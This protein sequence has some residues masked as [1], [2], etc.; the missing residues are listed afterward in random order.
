MWLVLATVLMAQESTEKKQ[1]KEKEVVVVATRSE[2]DVLDVAAGVT[3][4]TR[5]QIEKSGAS[6][7][8]DVLR[9]VPGF[10]A[11][12]PNPHGAD[13]LLDLRGYNN[14]AGNGQRTLVLVDGRRTNSPTSGG[15]DWA[16]IPLRNVERI[17]VVR[18][19]AAALYGDPA[20]AGVINII[21]R[22]EKKEE[23]RWR[24][25]AEGGSWNTAHGAAEV[26]GK[27]DDLEYRL[28]G[29][30]Q[31]TDGWRE[32]SGYD[33]VDLTADLEYPLGEGL[34][35]ALKIGVHDDERRRPGTLTPAD[36]AA[37]GRAGTVNPNDHADSANAY[38]DVFF[39]WE[40][41]DF[42]VVTAQLSFLDGESDAH[43]EFGGGD[44]FDTEDD[45][46]QIALHL[47]DV[48]DVDLLGLAWKLTVGTDLVHESSDALSDSVFFGSA[49]G[50]ENEYVRRLVG[51]FGHVE[52]R[53]LEALVLSGSLRWDRAL[54]DLDRAV[55]GAAFSPA[56]QKQKA[57][58]Q[59]SP[60]FGATYHALDELSIY[61]SYGRPFKYPTRD[62]LVGFS[63]SDPELQ[64]ERAHSFETGVRLW[65]PR[66]GSAGLGYYWMNV[67]NEIYFNPSSG[68]FG[69]NFNFERVS[70]RG[71][72]AEVRLTPLEPETP[73]GLEIF[74]VY[75]Y[76][77]AVIKSSGLDGKRYPVT[78]PHQGLLGSTIT[79][80]D[81]YLTLLGRF[82]GSRYQISDTSNTAPKLGKY[83]LMDT[84]VSVRWGK[85]LASLAVYNVFDREYFESGGLGFAGT[86]FNP[87]AERSVLISLEADF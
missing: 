50:T 81:V 64:P 16:T 3:V 19:G 80:S 43:D 63:A 8:V 9:T 67:K 72:E 44:F 25:L 23:T 20:L 56:V 51:L 49:A 10:F 87:G 71:I 33:A 66:W 11:Q 31:H 32:N 36:L 59:V 58:S 2:S 4:V 77:D 22:R 30:A 35:L 17:E 69:T 27:C 15:T 28:F 82:V 34:R 62:E 24:A 85:A 76:T 60:A 47:K 84:K 37:V 70:H 1:E 53:P 26:S 39:T 57:F 68:F 54:L 48:L 6:N 46:K 73:V 13:A 79:Y 7:I 83:A 40:G 41:G 5:E 45:Y 38:G 75:T 29:G 21:T 42:G 78:P 14:G 61:A 86:A 65:S 55:S 52:V 74:G 12:G 18:G